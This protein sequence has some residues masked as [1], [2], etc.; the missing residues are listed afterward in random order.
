MRSAARV[1]SIG[2]M[3]GGSF[4]LDCGD[5]WAQAA[6]TAVVDS[7]AAEP[8]GTSQRAAFYTEVA[9][10]DVAGVKALLDRAAELKDPATKSFA[11]DVLL[12]RYAELDPGAA[13]AAASKLGPSTNLV[14]LYQAW[15][16]SSPAAALSSLAKLEESQASYIVPSLLA[17]AGN[18]QELVN[19]I[20]AAA[21]KGVADRYVASSIVRLA[22]DSPRE[23]LE[24]A[25]EISNP[26]VRT[27]T[28][29]G[30]MRAWASHDPRTF[31]DYLATVDEAGRHSAASN[32]LWYQIAQS[33]PELALDRADLLPPELRGP[34][35]MSAIGAIAQRDP[36]AAY[37][38]AQQ[39]PQGQERRQLVHQI[40]QTFA[41]KDADAALAWARSLQPPE[42]DALAAVVTG[43]GAKDP[44]RALD[45][46]AAI[47]TPMERQQAMH[48][49]VSMAVIRDP[50][51]SGTL[52]DRALAL[53]NDQDRQSL[54]QA[55]LSM[56]GEKEPARAADWLVANADRAPPG[57]VNTVASAYA[58]HDLQQAA[59]YAT[60]MPSQLR[61][62]WLN[63]VAGMYAQNDPRAALT[64]IEQFRGSPEYDD[65]AL[66]VIMPASRVDPE[67]AARAAESLG[68]EDYRRTA[69]T[70][71]AMG[72]AQRD[73]ARA[74]AWASGV[75]DP[76]AQSGAVSIIAGMWS[77]QD[78]AAAQAWILSQPAGRTRDG[79]M[80]SL[81]SITARNSIP[82]D[83]LFAGFSDD[84]AR[85]AAVQGAAG[86]IAQRDPAAARAFVETHVTDPTQRERLLNFLAQ[87]PQGMMRAPVMNPITG[88]IMVPPGGLPA[89]LGVQGTFVCGPASAGPCVPGAPMP[90]GVIGAVSGFSMSSGAQYPPPGFPPPQSLP[91]SQ[92]PPAGTV[93]PNPTPAGSPNT[94]R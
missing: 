39:M 12:T 77:Q 35:V 42:P 4:G 80:L 78:P 57:A 22:Q 49:V 74:A 10:A 43:I 85:V 69:V 6:N 36:L 90:A 70:Q 59:S 16:R 76:A 28:V 41:Q 27:E 46:A 64:W 73:P 51:L 66:A 15:L 86:M 67:A 53:P 7:L 20:L 21:P 29:N 3:L 81:I 62:S 91:P 30:V 48:Q 11:V 61:G 63:G 37:A 23:A 14:A 83:S 54:V 65:A 56:W 47:S 31:L 44:I 1:L 2:I 87:V 18:D 38:R 40:A 68:R 9:R 13:V 34:V 84:R 94:Q 93:A 33:A 75:S 26:D 24:R 45:L 52:L 19:E 58:R 17:R 72:W 89:T 88:G 8:T 92:A 25:Q 50:A 55:I 82:D 5:A 71:V 79:A 60:R 32:G